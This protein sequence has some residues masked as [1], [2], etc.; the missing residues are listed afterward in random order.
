MALRDDERDLCD[1]TPDARPRVACAEHYEC[2][3]CHG[4]GRWYD[5]CEW[6]TCASCDGTGCGFASVCACGEV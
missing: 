6:W 5:G 3:V 1:A 4:S 2:S